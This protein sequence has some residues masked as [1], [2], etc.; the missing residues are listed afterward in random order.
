[1]A[2]ADNG[3]GTWADD[4]LAETARMAAGVGVDHGLPS[5]VRF[6]SNVAKLIRRRGAHPDAEHDSTRPAIFLLQP[7]PR[8]L[9]H[10]AAPKH[11]PMLDNAQTSVNGRIWFVGAVVVSGRYIDFEA[12]D[13]D[14][15]FTLITNDMGQGAV[16]TIIFDPRLPVPEARYYP[17]GLDEPDLYESISV[18][19]TDV[20]LDRVFEAIEGTYNDDMITP[21]QQTKPGKLWHN[22]GKWWPKRDAEDRIQMYLK[23]G[24]NRAFRTCDVRH[25]KVI[26]EGRLDLIIEERDPIDREIVTNHAVL[27]L[28]VLRSY[29]EVGANYTEEYNRDWIKKGVIQAHGYRKG[30][31]A[32]W[33]ALCC[34]DMRKSD[35]GEACFEHVRDMA[36]G[37]KVHLKRWFLYAKSEYLRDALASS[38]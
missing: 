3:R 21:E 18:T 23:I 33:S 37:L 34:F 36:K 2:D 9:E 22:Q 24:L 10:G 5:E 12:T 35:T 8:E 13:D 15:M 1:M 20:T 29:G 4:D 11:E 28:K 16:P 25:E 31:R 38:G 6:V 27:E 17:N 26:A 19:S 32:K 30:K 14:S 7:S